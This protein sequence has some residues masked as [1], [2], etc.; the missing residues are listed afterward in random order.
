M[1][2]FGDKI[3]LEFQRVNDN[4]RSCD[5]CFFQ[6]KGKIGCIVLED[7]RVECAALNQ[8]KKIEYGIWARID[9]QQQTDEQTR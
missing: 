1:A 9:T 4:S 8:D 3:V 6:H 7:S 5:G 2:N